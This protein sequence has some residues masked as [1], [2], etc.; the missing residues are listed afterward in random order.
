MIHA[1]INS[2]PQHPSPAL[3]GHLTIFLARGV[4]H[5]TREGFQKG[6]G[7]ELYPGGVGNLNLSSVK[8]T[9]FFL[10]GGIHEVPGPWMSSRGP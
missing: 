2:N 5:L 1:P 7:F 3:P 8:L 6:G 10:S 4:R 9:V